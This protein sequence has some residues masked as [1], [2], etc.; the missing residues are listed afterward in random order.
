MKKVSFKKAYGTF[1]LVM[2]V[3]AVASVLYI[4]H[5]LVKYEASQPER[6]VEEQIELLSDAAMYGKIDT[7]LSI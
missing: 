1:L 2:L 5:L 7:V 3:L 6:K 4:R